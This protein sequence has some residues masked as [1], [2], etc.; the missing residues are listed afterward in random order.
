LSTRLF[1]GS[2]DPKAGWISYA[3]SLKQP[4]HQVVYERRGAPPARFVTVLTTEDLGAVRLDGPTDQPEVI[5]R[6]KTGQHTRRVRLGT[7]G[8]AVDE[9]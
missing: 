7:E 1:Y 8:F 6:V 3:Y 4:I 5:L 9:L 2:D